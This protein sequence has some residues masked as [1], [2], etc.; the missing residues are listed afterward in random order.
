MLVYAT[1][2]TCAALMVLLVRRYDLYEKEPWYM[3]TLAVALGAGLMWTAGHVED[4][5]LARIQL[6]PGELAAKAALVAGVEELGKLLV[7]VIIA[8]AFARHFN[9]PLDGLVYGTLGGLGMAVEESLLYLSLTPDK[10]ALTLGAEIVRL[11]AHSLMGGLLGFAVGLTLRQPASHGGRRRKVALPVTCVAVSVV[12]HFCWNYIAY[13][14][15]VATAMRGVLMLLM[16]CLMIVW[17]ATVA[18]A[19]NLNRRFLRADAV[20]VGASTET[21]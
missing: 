1:L 2:F 15:H 12:V 10:D 20:T 11:F 21:R 19:M 5:L 3:V 17:G 8:L 14:P 6:A 4:V 18:Y 16:L 9:D 7:P 13:R